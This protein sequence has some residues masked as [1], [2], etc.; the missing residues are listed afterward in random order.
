MKELKARIGH[1]ETKAA[2]SPQTNAHSNLHTGQSINSARR[3]NFSACADSSRM[4]AF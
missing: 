1:L 4:E 2:A 3:D